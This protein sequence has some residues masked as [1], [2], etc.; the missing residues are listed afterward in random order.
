MRPRSSRPPTGS[1][2]TPTR[3]AGEL[4]DLYDADPSRVV[5]AEPGVDLAVF[6]P[7][8]QRE[9]RAELGIPADAVLLL[10]V[11]RIQPLKA[12]DVLV[13]AAAELV[14]RRPDLRDRVVVAILGGASG[15]GRAQP[16]G[17]HRARRAARHR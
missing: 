4:V 5:V 6:H 3:E 17:P 10:F 11:G 9:A 1:S 16:D 13:K 14:R 12:P 2:P 8:S 15:S 7:G